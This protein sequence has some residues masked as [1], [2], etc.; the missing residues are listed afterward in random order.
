MKAGGFQGLY[1]GLIPAAVGSAP[2]AA[3]FFGVYENSKHSLAN[4]YHNKNE[5]KG[6]SSNVKENTHAWI[7]MVS[8]GI[9]ECAACLIR[10]PTEVI[11]Q[12]MQVIQKKITEPQT[13]TSLKIK[14]TS[15]FNQTIE[16]MRYIFRTEGIGG[17]YTGFFSTIIREIPFSFIQFP[18]YEY[19]KQEVALYNE[20]IDYVTTSI[21][22]TELQASASSNSSSDFEIKRKKALYQAS[23]FQAALCGSIAGGIAAAVTTP[24]DVVKTRLM[25]KKGGVGV[26]E[27][28]MGTSNNIKDAKLKQPKSNNGVRNTLIRIFREEGV[29]KLFSGIGPRTMWIS[30]G[31]WIFF[32]A[33]EQ[34]LHVLGLFS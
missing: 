13:S 9:G 8:A 16:T 33:Y 26:N 24:L 21:D 7:H 28:A 29:K 23:P 25:L 17:F 4:L 6:H 1:R 3:L 20:S 11:K 15:Q 19:F 27:E 34:S 31:G 14:P 12:N 10:V 18:L 32:G 22:T 5:D 2:G 30:I